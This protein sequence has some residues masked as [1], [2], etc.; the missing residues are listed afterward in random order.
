MGLAAPRSTPFQPPPATPLS[1][2]CSLAPRGVR[3]LRKASARGPLSRHGRPS[4]KGRGADER[5]PAWPPNLREFAPE[6]SRQARRLDRPGLSRRGMK[7]RRPE[8]GDFLARK[9][10]F[11]RSAPL[12]PAVR[13]GLVRKDGARALRARQPVRQRRPRKGRRPG[14][15]PEQG[16]RHL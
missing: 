7:G 14:K 8:R 12:T 16:R 11:Q 3:L 13:K 1:P 4:S 9:A 6:E 5:S 15:R 2:R 10:A